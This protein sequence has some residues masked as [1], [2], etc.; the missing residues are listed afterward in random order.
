MKS[1][2]SSVFLL[3]L[4]GGCYLLGRWQVVASNT[5]VKP[6]TAIHAKTT[7]ISKTQQNKGPYFVTLD[8]VRRLL[9]NPEVSW[10]D[11]KDYFA[12]VLLKGIDPKDLPDIIKLVADWPVPLRGVHGKN[13]ILI[14]LFGNL[15]K[16]N[17]EAALALLP[18]FP[19]GEYETRLKIIDFALGN[20]AASDPQHAFN[21]LAQYYPGDFDKI[22]AYRLL[23][24][25]WAD[26]NPA[27]AAAAALNLP[28]GF[29]RV[30]TLSMLGYVYGTTNPQAAIK[31]AQGLPAAEAEVRNQVI[32]TALSASAQNGNFDKQA[33]LTEINQVTDLSERNDLIGGVAGGLKT[34]GNATAAMDWLNQNSSG[35]AYDQQINSLFSNL[36]NTSP[37]SMLP[38]LAKITD[39]GV[40]ETAIG[41]LAKEWSQSNPTDALGWAQTLSDTDSTARVT[42]L[43]AI[44]PALSKTNPN[45]AATFVQNAADPSVYLSAAPAIAQNLATTD[46]QGALTWAG[47]LPEGA[48]KD[49]ALGNVLAT[50]AQTNP[51]TAW[52]YA[53][54]LPAGSNQDTVMTTI[55]TATAQKDPAQ[56]VSLAEQMP[57]GSAQVSAISSV[58]ATWVAQDPQTFT[59]W[60]NGLPAGDVRDAA[61]QQLASSSQVSKNIEGV[62][63]WVN[64]VSNP[65]TKAALLQ[66]LGQN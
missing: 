57:T 29:T 11:K 26:K 1:F 56:A 45:A 41:D 54:S 50:M 23:F 58:S 44:L 30:T 5:A 10:D 3:G 31:W 49:Q 17:P 21:L 59:T 27:D 35:A 16:A 53:T 15:L 48:G 61:I 22:H 60:L 36:Y 32:Y 33:T 47:N 64:T 14:D 18:S 20:I 62:L 25:A 24:G 39:P 42:A 40:R 8:D 4:V 38:A 52:N 13:Y 2:L 6:A 19:P 37:T 51:T 66:K 43:D 34:G 55:V 46:P 63:Q 9:A 7:P 28:P 65:Q 12:D